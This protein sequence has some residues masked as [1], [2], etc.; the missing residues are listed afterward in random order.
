MTID[1]ASHLGELGIGGLVVEDVVRLR[2]ET[3][4]TQ[5][6]E[7]LLAWLTARRRRSNQSS[8]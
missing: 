4:R 2:R 1:E 6:R 5:V 3:Y 7:Y 8:Y